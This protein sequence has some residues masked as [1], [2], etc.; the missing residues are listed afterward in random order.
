MSAIKAKHSISKRALLAIWILVA[1]LWLVSCSGTTTDTTVLS[2]T[3]A[4]EAAVLPPEETEADEAGEAGVIGLTLEQLAEYDGKDGNRAYVAID[5]VIYDVTDVP[6]WKDG[7]H[8]GVEAG[9][10]LTEVLT[11]Q[12]PHGDSVLADLPVVGNVVSE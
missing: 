7:M 8:N 3:I 9:K 6:A 11:G 1:A 2:E 12:S 10:D 4:T 5:G